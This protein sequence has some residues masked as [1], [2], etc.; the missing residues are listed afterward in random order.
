MSSVIE[1]GYKT[2]HSMEYGSGYAFRIQFS[3]I[4]R[5]LKEYER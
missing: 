3:G 5:S 1:D 4:E 2:V